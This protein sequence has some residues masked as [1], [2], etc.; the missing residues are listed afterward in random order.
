MTR[1]CTSYLL[2]YLPNINF[3]LEDISMIKRYFLLHSIKLLAATI[4]TFGLVAHA[5]AAVV[6]GTID[7]GS[8]ACCV[9]IVP[10]NGLNF[11][12]FYYDDYRGNPSSSA[13]NS[14]NFTTD[15]PDTT[16][17]IIASSAGDEFDLDSLESFCDDYIT[18]PLSFTATFHGY[19]NGT[20]VGNVDIT[21]THDNAWHPQ[22][23]GL[24]N[25][26]QVKI[27][28]DTNSGDNVLNI[29]NVV[30]NSP[31]IPAL[32]TVNLSVS[33]TSGTEAAATAITV[34]ATASAAVSGAQT[35]IV[36]V[37]GT[38]ITAGDYSLSNTTLTIPNG[39]TTG[40]VTFTIVDDA[41]VEGS[42]TATI[43]ISSPSSG[44]N[45]GSTTSQDVTIADN[46]VTLVINEIDYDNKNL[47]VAEFVELKNI[48]DST[49]NFADTPFT[50]QFLQSDGAV[51][52]TITLNSSSVLNNDYYV[53][54]NDS[55]KVLN[56]DQDE[57]NADFLQNST[58]AVVLKYD[59]NIVD[60]VSY[61]GDVAGYVEGTAAGADSDTEAF[62]SL[63][64]HPDGT[65]TNNNNSDFALKCITP[66][67]VN[68]ISDSNNCYALSI[69]DP[70]AVTEGNSGTTTITFTV[71]LSHAAASDVTVDYTTA[72]NTAL[73]TS[74]YTT[75]SDTLTFT[76]GETSKTIAVTVNGDQV[77]ESNET[78]KVNLTSP[79]NNA[80]LSA[81]AAAIEGIGTITDDDT[82]GF[83]LSETTASV[84]ESGTTDTFTVVL[85]SQPTSNVEISVT[86]GDTGEAT[87]SPATLTFTT[88]NWNTTQT[89][90]IT[91]VDDI[92]SDGDQNTTVTL[93]IV[94][95][96]SDDAFDALA[97]K[98]VTV[99]TVDN[100]TP[101]IS[102]AQ[103][104][105]SI[106]V[107]EGGASGSYPI[108]LSTQPTGNVEI[109]VTAN[110]QTQVSMDGTTFSNG[111]V[112]T[113]TNG[114][115]STAQT[116]TVKAI[117][118]T[119]I[120]GNHTATI[121]HAITGT[122]NDA[123]YPTT[124]T[125]GSVT[126]NITDNDQAP[127]NSGGGSTSSGSVVLP[128]KMQI[129]VTISGTG[130][131]K[132]VSQPSGIDCQKNSGTCQAIFPTN[133]K[134]TLTATADENS[135][136][137]GF[138]GHT[139]CGDGSLLLFGN[140]QCTVFF[141]KKQATSPPD[142]S[143]NGTDDHHNMI[144]VYRLWSYTWESHFYTTNVDERERTLN[145]EQEWRD[146]DVAYYV[147][148]ANDHP[149]NTHPVYRFWSYDWN[150]HFYTMNELEMERLVTYFPDQ[151]R[152]EEVAYYAYK[153][154]E[155]P[156]NSIPVYRFYSFEYQS[157]FYTTNENEKQELLTYP[158]TE[159]RY[160][161]VAWYVSKY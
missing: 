86:S 1:S 58:E 23:I 60:T 57:V 120:E 32:P 17:L 127:S 28:F 61:E 143:D 121:T 157:H 144:P 130:S 125:L 119:A 4:L 50:L 34:T 115:W 150:A 139:D 29:D 128:S 148:D 104:G 81:T 140:R 109:T 122:V 91:G 5:F 33:P 133:S 136:F 64:R 48:S 77:D 155:Q 70:T 20:P 7:F 62:V 134:I 146:E 118:D 85:D 141:I 154:G 113:F 116:V 110:A 117:D 87:V 152:Y 51:R 36:G 35:V 54:C 15:D 124:L 26:D 83:T 90:T 95:G 37:S 107:T 101:G 65:D 31:T 111:I 27:T 129:G 142:N 98:T 12:N 8:T 19:R 71:T 59:N 131:G 137:S 16:G 3:K 74:D 97:D 75:V 99:T 96:S 103:I 92:L 114:N 39:S 135:E 80:Q 63:S 105:G 6:P 43:A 46:D 22:T 112:L 123:N 156:V 93:S 73:A 159:W 41:A 158:Q 102:G 40:T 84:N 138:G 108:A 53:I 42:E 79:S 94:D 45:L 10:T 56:C 47:D 25:V 21:V 88:G 67:L 106:N 55:D 11:N 153:E 68:N 82:A 52:K 18:S 38:G 76:V 78:F 89:V 9:D 66:G 72:N 126:I 147:Y 2:V 132:V 160:E 161:G 44:I 49:I 151:W 149:E 100:D 30:I 13:V 69:N 24:Q 14:G 145:H